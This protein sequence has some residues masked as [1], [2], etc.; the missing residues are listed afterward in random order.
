GAGGGGTGAGAPGAEAG[1]GAGG[2]RVIG[3]T[4]DE[5]IDLL[6]VNEA[7]LERRQDLPGVDPT[8][9]RSVG[10]RGDHLF[11]VLDTDALLAPILSS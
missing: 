7:S 4:V 1:A 6:A 9:V 5:V 10:R 3:F 11:L 2:R 8:L